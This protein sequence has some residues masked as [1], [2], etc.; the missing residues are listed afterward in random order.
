MGVN[1]SITVSVSV[2]N[3]GSK[4]GKEVVHLFIS[5]LVATALS[6]DVKRLRGFDK[7]TLNAGESKTVEFNISIKDLAFINPNN[8]RQL[9]A[10][11]FKVQ[12]S[13]L[14]KTFKLIQ[15]IVF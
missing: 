4:P 11:D 13:N 7:V 9:E 15:S 8:K 14:D 12:V 10:G 3:T 6:P 5:D 2:K 1:E